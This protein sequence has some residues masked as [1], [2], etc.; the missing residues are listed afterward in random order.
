VQLPAKG[1]KG[2]TL[3]RLF[4][5]ARPELG[6][7]V[8]GTILL[9]IAS[10][11]GLLYPQGMRLVIDAALGDVPAWAGGTSPEALLDL[12]ILGMAIATVLSAIAM[13]LRFYFFNLA[14]ERTAARLRQTLFARLLDQEVAFFDAERTGDLTSRLAADTTTL[15]NTFSISISMVLR[16]VVQLVGGVVLLLFTSTK[17]ALLM[18]GVVPVIAIGAVIYGRRVRKLARAVQD[19]VAAGG[20]VA[21]ESIAGL[22]TVRSF[23]AE[24]HEVE[25]YTVANRV[26][27]AAARRRAINSG[28]F[29]TITSGSGYLAIALVFW[30]GGRLVLHDQLSPGDLTSFLVYTLIVGFA[31]GGLADLWADMMRALGAAERVFELLDRTPTIPATGGR[32][33]ER[34]AGGLELEDVDFVYPTRADTP[35]LQGLSLRVAPGETVALV[36]PSGAGKSTIAALLQRFY[37]PVRG[38]VRLDG[39]DLRQ[40]D[41]A[42]LRRQIGTVAQEPI[43]FSTSIL[44]NIRYGRPE[45]SRDEIVAAARAANADTF[46][47]AFPDGYDTQVG[48]RGVQLSGGQKQRIAIAR[49]VLKDPRVLILDEATS[50]LDAE[51]EFLVKEALER[52]MRGRTTLIIAHRLSTVK[53]AS[54]VVVL[55]HGKVAESGSHDALMTAGGIY[56]QL[57]SRQ[58]AGL[59]S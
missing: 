40:L 10:G 42:W 7:L 56:Q 58:V 35:V 30:Y 14:G 41:P 52:L 55:D 17:L 6:M 29:M 34:V 37:D 13:G 36:G 4:A 46:V 48:E 3:R 38:L 33:L 5:M 1:P 15:Q 49:A 25:R 12:L 22:R 45:A 31:L 27:L 54:R 18:L 24:P 59:E 32:Q 50:A 26:A 43:L 47:T 44:D 51:S 39:V 57:V 23:A 8:T 2:P 16:N 21:Q 19:A 11:I 20:A 9:A 53:D 28:L